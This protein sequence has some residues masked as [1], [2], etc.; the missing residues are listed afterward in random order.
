MIGLLFASQLAFAGATPLCPTT[1]CVVGYLD[2]DAHIHEPDASARYT[3]I[4]GTFRGSVRSTVDGAGASTI[5]AAAANRY[6]VPRSELSGA[7]ALTYATASVSVTST[8][9]NAATIEV[10]VTNVSGG[11]SS[12]QIWVIE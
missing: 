9:P 4:I 7:I 6:G 8:R 1:K 11:D 12:Y 2:A 5:S 3:V 10:N